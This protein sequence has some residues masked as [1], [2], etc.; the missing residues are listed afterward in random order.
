MSSATSGSI[1]RSERGAD[2]VFTLWFDQP[3]RSQNVL[4]PRAFDELETRLAES[5]ADGEVQS[6]VIRSAKPEGFCAGVDLR[7]I[8]SCRGAADVEAFVRRGLAVFERLSGLAV[9]TVAVIHGACLGAGLELALACRRRIAL[10]SAAPLQIGTPEVH[11]GL[12]PAWG[13]IDQL[14]RLMGP[15][16]GLDFLI[17]EPIDRLS[18]GPIARPRRPPGRGSRPGGDDRGDRILS[19]CGA[20]VAQGSVGSRLEPPSRPGRGAAGR[21]SGG[22]AQDA[23]DRCD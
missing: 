15:D 13:A 20:D 16:D 4:D 11:L 14:P 21:V 23:H 5:E 2:G 10:A 8:W 3:G 22:P 19:R 17:S 9:P 1:W 18:S 6:L 12:I 7:T